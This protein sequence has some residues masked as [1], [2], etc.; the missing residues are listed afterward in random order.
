MLDL[1]LTNGSVRTFDRSKPWASAIGVKDGKISYVGDARSVPG[2]RHVVDLHGRLVTPGIVDSHVHLL[3]GFDPDDVVLDDARTLEEVRRR[4]KDLSDSRPDLRW[5]CGTNVVYSVVAGRTPNARDLD[6]VS[7]RP[8]FVM[9]YDGHCAWLNEHAL[10]ALGILHGGELAWGR[11][12]RDQN[13]VATGWIS[14]FYNSAMSEAGSIELPKVIPSFSHESRY[15]KLLAS[16]R[17]AATLGITTA[18]EPQVPLSEAEL[19]LKARS[20][21]ALPTRLFAALFHPAG[22]DGEFRKRLRSIVDGAGNDARLRFGNVKLYAD[23]VVEP[24]TA[25]MLEDYANRPGERGRAFYEPGELIAVMTELDRLGFRVHTHAIGDWGIR[26]TLDAIEQATSTNG[27]IDRRHGIVHVESLH[28][29]DL[30]RFAELGVVAAMQPRH[31]SPDFTSG[32]WMDNV[33]EDRWSQAWRIRSLMESGAMVALSSD[34]TVAEMDPLVGIY[35]ALTRATLDGKSAWTLDERISLDQALYGYTRGGA[36][37]WKVENELGIIAPGMNADLTA[38]SENLYDLAAEPDALLEV[39][40]DI[41][42]VDGE[43]SFDRLGE[44]AA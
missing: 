23:D 36:K 21:D 29:D 22:S 11:V 13:G 19:L 34:W 4:L 18:V 39:H 6:G 24:H 15:R 42:I 44:A 37:A 30:P 14:D 41:T 43:P 1:L 2:A 5:V 27:T 20:E 31:A 40:A 12:N 7:D 35:S 38:W 26:M 33:G 10:R 28:P 25:A 32:A 3:H 8:I 17:M 9:S 16:S